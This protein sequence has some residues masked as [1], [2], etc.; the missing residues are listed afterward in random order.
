M[1]SRW[2]DADAKE[3]VSRYTAQGVSADLALRTYT[4]RLLGSD[5]K[6]VLHGGGNTSVKTTAKDQLGEDVDVL[7]VKGSG[8]DMGNIE[9]QGLPAVRLHE[10]RRLRRLNTLSDEDMV[11][12]QRINL[13]DST[14]P[15]PSVETLLHA[16]LPHKFID[17]THSTAV[18]ALTDQPDGEALA[19]GIYGKRVA[20]VPYFIPGFTL[21]KAVADVF[22]ANPK[23]EGLILPRHGIFTFAEDARTAYER[24]IEFVTMAEERLQKDRK[25]LK[26]VALPKHIAHVADIGPILRGAVAIEKNEM[27]GTVKR[28]ILCFRSSPAI[29]NYVN[30]A[31]IA[32]YS[33]QGVVTPDHTIRTK[34]WP[35]IVPAPD[36]HRLDDWKKDVHGAV[37]KF[38]ARYHGYFERNNETSMPKKKELDPLPRVVLVPGVGMFGLGATAKDAAIAAD[39]AENTIEVITDAEAIGEYRCISE[40]DMFEVEYWSLEQAKLGKSNEK[41]LSRQVCVITGG[42]SGIGAATAKAMAAEGAEIAILDRD[43]DMAVK[44]ARAVHNHALAIQCDVTDPAS[45]RAAFDKVVEAFGGVDIV[46]SNAGAAWQ[47]NIGSVEDEVL[48]KSF[49]L[50]FFAHQTVAQN[51]VKI[52]RAQGTYGCLLF[53]T[54]K[55]AVNPGKDFGPYGLPKAAT[56]FLVRQY[57]LDHG[58]DGIRANAV[59]ADRVRSGLLTDDMVAA[60][61]KARGVSEE[62]Y[63]S[64]NLLGREVYAA[65]VAEAFVYL[66][67]AEKTTAAVIT[68]DGGNI[69]AA[70]R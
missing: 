51:A 8:W 41:T 11:N 29:L 54:S 60:R 1:K 44:A 30:G 19:R 46:V 6:L 56:L 49:E 10:L 43:H 9:P 65:E 15:N 3:F 58:K 21:A 14:A 39:I 32:R 47:G 59:N 24:M 57:A 52:M 36:A 35:L 61:S 16:F 18:L 63:M 33:Q 42:G 27:A 31:E 12:F 40:N 69:E 25:P 37:E 66:A 64:G 13:L 20:Y 23:V 50:N 70:L 55:Q 17:H 7:C 2:S 38:V 34:N 4:T 67:H 26:P 68:V 28:Q 48:R 62:T 5:P 53:N 45:V 22:D